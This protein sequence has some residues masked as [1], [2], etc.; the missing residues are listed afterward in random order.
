[1]VCLEK[2]TGNVLWANTEISGIEGYASPVIMEYEGVRQVISANGQFYYGLELKTGKLLWKIDCVNQRELNNTDAVVHENYVF[3][4]SGYGKGSMLYQLNKSEKGF[5]PELIWESV[6]MDNHHG[7]VILHEGYLYGSG[8]KS[9]GWFCLDFLS[10]K[11]MWK[12]SGKGSIT[13]A[14]GRLYLLDERGV[15]KLAEAQPGEYIQSGEFEVPEGGKSMYWAHP[16]VCNGVLYI[17]HSD[18]LFAY[19]IK[20]K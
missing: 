16:V 4:S 10:G 1:M 6:L 2:S 12:T 18:R 11:E 8:S 13:F 19:D 15:M 17:R 14:D 20:D 5:V 9:R 3:I 7:G